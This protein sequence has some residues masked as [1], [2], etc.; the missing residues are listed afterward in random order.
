[1]TNVIPLASRCAAP[2]QGARLGAPDPIQLHADAH[3]A[4]AMALH[5]LRHAAA[6]DMIGQRHIGN[7]IKPTN[8]LGQEANGFDQ[9]K[10]IAFGL[11]L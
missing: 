6:K 8:F 11:L 9:E 7:T 10:S 1:M 2:T 3:N 5:Y 4:L